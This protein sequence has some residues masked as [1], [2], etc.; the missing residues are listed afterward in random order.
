MLENGVVPDAVG[1]GEY[2]AAA[3]EFGRAVDHRILELILLPT[4]DCNFRCVY[5]YEDFTIGKM[6]RV[7]V[8]AVKKLLSR[9]APKLRNLILNWF[10]GEPLV[11]RDIVESISKTALDLSNHFGFSYM[12]SMTT[13]GAL[14]QSRAAKRLV[15]LGVRQYQISL[16]GW[17]EG[18]DQTRRRRN[19]KGSFE[20]IWKNILDINESKMDI[21]IILRLH[22]TKNNVESI[23][24]LIYNI[25]NCLS[26]KRFRIFIK[27]IED[28]GGSSISQSDILFDDVFEKRAALNYLKTL[29]SKFNQY[30]NSRQEQITFSPCYAAKLN[31]FVIRADGRIGKCTVALKDRRNVIGRL[32]EDGTMEIRPDLIALWARGWERFDRAAL[33]CPLDG[34]PEMRMWKGNR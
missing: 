33:H 3:A 30:E 28:L 1:E 7:V 23:E 14:L 27:A 11:A 21:N 29:S 26:P 24:K 5:C 17:R 9:R 19:G 16:D 22:V 2:E 6:P 4:E 31:S 32:R 18:H 13:N 8:D 12:G 25:C 34:L 20:R 15:D 10:G